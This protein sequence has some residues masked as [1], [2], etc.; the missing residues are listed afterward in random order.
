MF[1]RRPEQADNRRRAGRL[2][3]QDLTC[4]L[5]RVLDLS[6]S[7]VRIRRRLPPPKDLRMRLTITNP[8]VACVPVVARVVRVEQRG[9]MHHEIALT[10]D[11]ADEATKQALAD[12]ARSCVHHE[13]TKRA[14]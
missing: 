12:L 11:D 8:G 7:G 3:C 9:F 13:W 2:Q 4:S 10:F 14:A 5:G 1:P 6:S